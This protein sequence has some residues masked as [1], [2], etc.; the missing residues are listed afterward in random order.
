MGLFSIGTATSKNLES[1]LV[2]R[3]FAGLFASAATSI[4]PAALGDIFEPRVRATAMGF[5]TGF[6]IGGPSLAPII[7]AAATTNKHLGWRC[8]ILVAIT[9]ENKKANSL[10]GLNTLK[11]SWSSASFSSLS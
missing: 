3:F 2:T 8:K 6:V 11:Q 1:M 9:E 10:K 4:G 5:W 7:G